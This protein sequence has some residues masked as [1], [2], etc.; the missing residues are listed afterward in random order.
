LRALIIQNVG[1]EGPG[2]LLPAMIEAGWRPD[3]RIMDAPE[4]TLPDGLTGYRALVVLGGP[5]N[6]Y[7]ETAYPH[8]RR[9]LD[10]ISDALQRRMPVL[11]ICLGAQL[12]ARALGAP[13]TRNPVK[14]IGWYP[15]RLTAAGAASPPFAGLPAEFYVFQWHGDT[16]ALPQGADLLATGAQCANQAFSYAGRV[17]ALQFHLEVTAEMINNWAE[18]YADELEEFGGREARTELAAET[19][20]RATEYGRV[21]DCFWRNWLH[22]AGTPPV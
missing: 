9:V 15:V 8:L 7:E 18:V 2:S 11:G 20:V 4:A 19:I 13:V 14:E 5:M 17:L 22:Y 10:L 21:A 6:V 12:I 1:I 3:I 16:F